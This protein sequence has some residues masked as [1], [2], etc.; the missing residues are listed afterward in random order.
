[1]RIPA[2]NKIIPRILCIGRLQRQSI[3]SLASLLILTLTGFISTMY[4]AHLLGAEGLGGYK[5]FL[6]YL[7]V[8]TLLTE[9]GI[10][11]AMVK[12][13]S[14]G[15]DSGQYYSASVFLRILLLTVVIAGILI[16]KP[17]FK[18]LTSSGLYYLLILTI[19]AGGT[20]N[21]I[22]SAV[23]GS[24]KVGISQI[25]SLLN[26]TTRITTQVITVFSGL[27]SAGLAAGHIA[28]FI[29]GAAFAFRF[30]TV[31][32]ARFGM[33]HI[34]SIY[35]YAKWSF[36]S[37][38]GT[39]VIAYADTILVG[40][41]LTNYEVGIYGIS[42]Q[43]SAIAT[44]A[45]AAMINTLFPQV[46]FWHREEE[47][48]MIKN[49]V[50][51]SLAYALIP[52]IPA[53]FGGIILGDSILYFLYGADFAKGTTALMMILPAQLFSIFFLT[54][55]MCLNAFNRPRESF[56]ITTSSAAV[57]ILLNLLLI[58]FFGINGSALAFLVTMAFSALYSA[59]SLRETLPL[60][61][62]I[63]V[64]KDTI[65]ASVVMAAAVLMLKEVFPPDSWQVLFIIVISGSACY[66]LIL[67]RINRTLKEDIL[68]I[69]ADFGFTAKK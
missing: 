4:F 62:D 27:K 50:G 22:I 43:F 53:V 48:S 30:R 36:L 69:L 44:L 6:A 39:T 5:I 20:Y 65:M 2:V 1:M 61:P 7:A 47:Y 57:N 54:G 31:R 55:I 14:E 25:S 13:I 33:E 67:L 26:E 17:V 42:L 21:L 15:G 24:G 3:I 11:A 49:A 63:P 29:I 23:Y 45:A 28:G 60:K 18:D 16:A 37:G 32:L 52:A 34:R 58:P 66:L 59:V 35:A 41:F 46:S 19:I 51:K 8:F 12:R 56:R 68:K 64:V 38:A 9:G 40:Y 10:S